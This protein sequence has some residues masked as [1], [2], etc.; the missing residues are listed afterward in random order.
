M[1]HR[2]H[3]HELHRGC[4]ASAWEIKPTDG[5]IGDMEANLAKTPK[6]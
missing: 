2:A 1:M 4:I 6:E 5:E 3:S